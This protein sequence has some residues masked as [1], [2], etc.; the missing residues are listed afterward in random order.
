MEMQPNLLQTCHCSAHSCGPTCNPCN[1]WSTNC[2]CVI[3][4]VL[5][6]FFLN[7]NNTECP[8]FGTIFVSHFKGHCWHSTFSQQWPMRMSGSIIL[9]KCLTVPSLVSLAKS[10]CQVTF[11]ET[12]GC[13]SFYVYFMPTCML[14]TTICPIS[15]KEKKSWDTIILN[16]ITVNGL[17]LQHFK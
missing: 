14:N 4:R 2:H 10:Q 9:Q 6:A 7:N 13:M 11:R 15:R 5:I 8:I 17:G 16:T 1:G 3:R 12:Y